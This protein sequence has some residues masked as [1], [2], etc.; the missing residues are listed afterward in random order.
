MVVSELYPTSL[1]LSFR[2]KK[3]RRVIFWC[4]LLAG[5]LAGVV[6]LLMSVTGVLLA[7]EKQISYWADT[8]QYHIAPP[9]SDARRL[10]VETLLARVRETQPANPSSITT[11]SA[12]DAPASF[13]YTGGRNIYVNPYTG[14]MLGEGSPGVRGFFRTVTDW[15]RWLGA[16]GDTRPAARAV[17]GAANLCFLFLV[18]SG[19]YLWWP[20]AFT[21]KHFRRGLWFRR[22]IS[23]KARDFNW[24]NVIGF[25]SALPLFVVVLSAVVISY[26]WASNL[27]YRLAGE[28]PP[29]PRAAA[30]P[31]PQQG[32][33][34]RR[35]ESSAAD[36]L[37]RSFARA[38][39][40]VPGWK[41]VSLQMPTSADAPLTFTIDSGSGGQPQK[42]AQLVLD[43]ASGEVVRW[44]PFSSYTAG[45]RLRSYLRF[46]HTG[47]VA[48]LAGQTIAAL[49]SLGG[50]FL[51][52]TGLSLAWRRLRGWS[53]RRKETKQDS[54]TDAHDA[55][56]GVTE[57]R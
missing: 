36:G 27:V 12:P 21:R 40:Q 33:T 7:Y 1:P 50:A 30:A 56:E 5:T 2:M 42:R 29:A 23:G 16:K 8:R 11:R 20:R 43:R 54:A 51:V 46:A 28:A 31:A 41:S 6:I 45:R 49:V 3:L 37:E 38:E 48:G 15:H 19:F 9:S 25:W 24:H 22:G 52:W 13:G 44:E 10:P 55:S 4:H 18:M 57:T 35:A 14:E 34:E 47:E 39:Q 26:T 32:A 53:A 17:T